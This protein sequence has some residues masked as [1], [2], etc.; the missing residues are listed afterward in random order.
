MLPKVTVRLPAVLLLVIA[1]LVPLCTYAQPLASDTVYSNPDFGYSFTFP[2]NWR[3]VS[4]DRSGYKG[5]GKYRI[6]AV[7]RNSDS[8]SRITREFDMVAGPRA[9]VFDLNP[10]IASRLTDEELADFYIDQM[11]NEYIDFTVLGV[12]RN[13]MHGITVYEIRSQHVVP[14]P[15]TMIR[16]DHIAFKGGNAY[17]W[18]TDYFTTFSGDAPALKQIADSVDIR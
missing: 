2:Q 7:I 12:S 6:D 8:F 14:G 3:Q 1:A 16:S 11:N 13:S 15:F 9:A 4:F 10:K 18:S 5:S 17:R